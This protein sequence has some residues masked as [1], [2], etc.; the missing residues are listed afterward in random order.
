MCWLDYEV[1]MCTKLT[2]AVGPQAARGLDGC[3]GVDFTI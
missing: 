1:Y 3:W 2:G